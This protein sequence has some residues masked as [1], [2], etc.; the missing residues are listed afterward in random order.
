MIRQ[1]ETKGEENSRR[2]RNAREGEES[3]VRR[4][5]NPSREREKREIWGEERKGR[6]EK[7]GGE[8]EEG[9]WKRKRKEERGRNRLRE[10][11]R[12]AEKEK[13]SLWFPGDESNFHRQET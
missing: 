9:D 6:G 1:G 12:R 13:F 10:K 4:K 3:I 2:T 5:R 11:R 7:E 8:E